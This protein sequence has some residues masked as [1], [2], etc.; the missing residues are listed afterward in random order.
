MGLRH[1]GCE[2]QR[3]DNVGEEHNAPK[4]K[5]VADVGPATLLKAYRDR[6]KRIFREE[7]R[8]PD[9]DD[10]EAKWI[11]QARD[12]LLRFALPD[13]RQDDRDRKAGESHPDAG[14]EPGK[15]QR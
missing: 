8:A 10:N 5:R 1:Y 2:D 4:P 7:L 12:E 9:D 15:S 11:E 6:I 13:R 14:G 3:T